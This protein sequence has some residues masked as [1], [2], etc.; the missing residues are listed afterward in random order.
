M[1]PLG[2]VVCMPTRGSVSVET[3]L[4]LRERMDGYPNEL[5]TAI[6][7]P[8]VEARNDLARQVRELDALPFDPRYV[9]WVDDDAWWPAGSVQSAVDTLEA[10]PAIDVL[11]G[12]FSQRKAGAPAASYV[13]ANFAPGKLVR[14][15]GCG[16]HWVLMRRD[17]LQRVGSAPFTPE[18]DDNGEDVSFCIR[19]TKAG[20]AVVAD[21]SLTIGHV[22]AKTGMVYFPNSP[23]L[24]G[25]GLDA[26]YYDRE[27][28]TNERDDDGIRTYGLAREQGIIASA[29]TLKYLLALQTGRNPYERPR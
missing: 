5:L 28:A 8:V 25:C 2:L 12:M 23:P 22:N 13:E 18:D 1:N 9:L 11:A 16:F 27:R 21:T 24:V 17:L 19:A 7:K 29:S 20:A 15:A 4:C 14:V 6:R 10:T 3:M 26:P